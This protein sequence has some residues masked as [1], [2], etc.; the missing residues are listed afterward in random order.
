[1]EVVQ[2]C[3]TT[4]KELIDCAIEVEDLLWEFDEKEERHPNHMFWA[5]I[6]QPSS[7]TDYH[8]KK[9]DEKKKPKHNLKLTDE[10]F[11]E[12]KAKG[13]CY[14]CEDKYTPWHYYKKELCI[15]ITSKVSEDSNYSDDDSYMS[16]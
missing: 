4:V 6:D 1:M 16:A 3:P 14:N 11:A 15:V 2:S 8:T 5:K 10:E 9:T 12:R 7:N 13:L